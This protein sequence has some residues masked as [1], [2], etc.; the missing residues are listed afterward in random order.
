MYP[1]LFRR[2]Y[3]PDEIVELSK[4]GIVRFSDD[5]IVT[6]WQTIKPRPD[7]AFGLSCYY[8]SRGVKISKFFDKDKQFM[9][10]YCDIIDTEKFEDRL[11]FTDLLLDCI[12]YENDFVKVMDLAELGEMLKSGIITTDIACS[13][14]DIMDG[15][16]NDIYS[17]RFS[18][19]TAILDTTEI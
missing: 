18:D 17:G 2:R 10:Y 15:L 3:V 11:V 7:F 16:L 13:A 6:K 1:K 8:I 12:V 4:D 5:I 14:L 9:Y 19:L